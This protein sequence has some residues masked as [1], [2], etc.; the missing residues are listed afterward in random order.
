MH[1]KHFKELLVSCLTIND[2]M[3]SFKQVKF[4]NKGNSYFFDKD[5]KLVSQSRAIRGY[6]VKLNEP[7]NTFF[8]LM[9]YMK[10]NGMLGATPSNS[11]ELAYASFLHSFLRDLS[12]LKKIS[13]LDDI[14]SELLDLYIQD[15][16]CNKN[17][18]N[19]TVRS[20]IFEF[21]R[22]KEYGIVLPD[23][24]SVSESLLSDSLL[25]DS[26][27]KIAISE[28]RRKR[29]GI[30]RRETYPLYDLKILMSKSIEYIEKYKKDVF[31]I[32]NLLSKI[33]DYNSYKKNN[34]L[35]QYFKETE[36]N[37]NEPT[38]T[39]VKNYCISCQNKSTKKGFIDKLL[40]VVNIFEGSCIAVTLMMTG[41]RGSELI[42]LNRNLNIDND[43]HFNL[44]R[45]IYKTAETEEGEE[46]E[47]P[48]PPI[49]KTALESLAELAIIKDGKDNGNLVLTAL[50]QIAKVKPVVMV[51][52]LNNLL[53]II[54]KNF[55]L[56][57]PITSHQF[58]HAMAYLITHIYE[59]DGLELARMFLGHTSVVMT[60]QYM[61]HY[62][63]ELKDAVEEL[64]QEESEYFI[65]KIVDEIR[66]NK[67]LFGENGKRLMNNRKFQGVQ[68]DEY[69][70]LMRQGL[71]DLV[72][73]KQL[74]I[75]QTP[76]SLCMHD[77]SKPES[78]SC[79]R[80]FDILE[81]AK[82][83]P[84][85]SRCHGASCSNAV[86][87]EEHIEKIKEEMHGDIDEELRKRLEKNTYFMEA[88]GFEQDPQRKVLQEYERYKRK[89]E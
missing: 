64:E 65:D 36:I 25:F 45:I 38:L 77:L 32:V 71:V 42:L 57:N 53:G 21:I 62:N 4:P 69:V 80:G 23:F 70:K 87:L 72:N 84:A 18:T 75:I 26:L 86:F 43:E 33:K 6:K 68:V 39:K 61:S 35:Y 74:A 19:L 34:Y 46:L 41:M 89:V 30:G 12:V 63:T 52:R 56:K 3:K 27:N 48:I 2:T 37:F 67:R 55:E 88:G 79:Q 49:C 17:V 85:P 51:S 54:C 9:L 22:C 20:K 47:M 29:N 44:K 28:I 11:G 59:S 7:L 78:L 73:K 5:V 40:N 15:Q 82:Y 76:V 31:V 58:R 14:D 10:L 8:R 81:I 66:S 83:G 50:G 60:L 1:H 16:L 24:L 13:R